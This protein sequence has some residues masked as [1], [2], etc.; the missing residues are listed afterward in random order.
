MSSFLKSSSGV[1]RGASVQGTDIASGAATS[2]QFLAANGSGG[3]AFRSLVAG[4]IPSLSATY[5]ALTGGTMSG[6][7]N[8]GSN[9]INSVANPTS[10][11]DAATKIYVDNAAA[12]INPAVSV[13]AASTSS[14]DLS[15]Y[16]YN[17]G[18]SGIGATLTAGSTNTALTVDGYTF[19]ALGQRLLEKDNSTAAYNGVYYVTQVQTA[20]LPIILTRA[21]DYDQPSDINNTG[22]IPV[23]N[24]TVNN[25]TSWLL[26]TLVNTVG[27]D[28]LTYEKF[29][30]NPADYL[31]KASNLSDVSSASS[32]FNNIA[33]STTEGDLIYYH[34]GTN[35][36]L[37][38]GANNTVLTSNGTDP[39]YNLLT[40]SNLSGS[41]AITNANLA[42]MSANTI[43][44]N[45]TGSSATPTDLSISQ[46]LTMLGIRAGTVSIS[47]SAT[48]A[49][50][51]FGTAYSSTNY[52][53]HAMLVN[54]TDSNPQF[55]PITITAQST[56]GFTA[57]WNIATATANY[58][59]QYITVGNN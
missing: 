46:A 28:A 32:S 9:Q 31:L 17:N 5:L 29:T 51:T 50:V 15:G 24:G 52:A 54:T 8:L 33:P 37:G 42:Q 1:P 13:Q 55:Q 2:T 57:T 16:T 34:S 23:L 40:N 21:L 43:K 45:N 7:I 48:S 19:T 22:I 10:A 41:A 27:T 44:G 38:I 3:S 4:D 6:A 36:R 49:S 14:S 47:S 25:T 30:R 58:S 20:L 59:L 11:Q 35:A 18:V 26:T 56:T 12:G 53:I 39:S